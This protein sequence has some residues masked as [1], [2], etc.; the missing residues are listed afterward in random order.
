ME[1]KSCLASREQP[2]YEM[3]EEKWEQQQQKGVQ[4]KISLRAL[5]HTC[6]SAVC[7]K[8]PILLK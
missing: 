4:K 3:M 7:G 5:D 2:Q 6:K 8:F 1:G